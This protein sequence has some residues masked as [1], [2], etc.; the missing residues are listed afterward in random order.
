MAA[1]AA[2]TD[3]PTCPSPHVYSRPSAVIAAV[4]V[5]PTLTRTTRATGAQFKE[6]PNITRFGMAQG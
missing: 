1:S 6:G 2:C 3:T 4:C 5:G